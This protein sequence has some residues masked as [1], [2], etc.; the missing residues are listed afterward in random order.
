LEGEVPLGRLP[1]VIDAPITTAIGTTRADLASWLRIFRAAYYNTETVSVRPEDVDPLLAAVQAGDSLFIT[2]AY[3]QMPLGAA[4]VALHLPTAELVSVAVA[5][6][7]HSMGLEIAL[8]TT[9]VRA[10]L[11]LGSSII[12]TIAPPEEYMPLYRRL[13]FIELANLLNFWQAEEYARRV[14]ESPEVI[15]NEGAQP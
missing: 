14:L 4:R 15:T 6:F 12:F 2:A 11:E 5:P 1:D 13:G 10:A 9:A 3:E 8:I 7:W